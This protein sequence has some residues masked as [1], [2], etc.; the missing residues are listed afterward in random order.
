MN[1]NSHHDFDTY[2]E[3]K[4]MQANLEKELIDNFLEVYEKLEFMNEKKGEH[5]ESQIQQFIENNKNKIQNSE[6][7][8]AEFKKKTSKIDFVKSFE[9]LINCFVER[10]EL[11][12]EIELMQR[13]YDFRSF[14]TKENAKKIRLEEIEEKMNDVKL[15]TKEINKIFHELKETEK[16]NNEEIGKMREYG[17]GIHLDY[18]FKDHR[19]VVILTLY[20]IMKDFLMEGFPN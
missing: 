12:K 8:L 16:I 6:K 5:I 10:S 17:S 7:I 9:S 11:D 1:P 2:V 3:L 14:I 19:F 20:N 4:I 15:E 18:F 13:K